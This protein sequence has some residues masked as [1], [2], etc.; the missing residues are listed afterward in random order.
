VC[1][2]VMVVSGFEGVYCQTDID[3]CAS[4]PCQNGGVCVDKIAK[5]EC[6][7][8][9]GEPGDYITPSEAKFA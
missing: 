8:P 5:F 4:K 2:H 1:Q 3:E 6:H 7:C 9:I